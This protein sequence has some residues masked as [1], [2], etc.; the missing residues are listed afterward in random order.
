VEDLAVINDEYMPMRINPSGE[1]I[2]TPAGVYKVS[3]ESVV[4]YYPFDEQTCH[5]K[6][7]TSGYTQGEIDLRFDEN[8]VD[9]SDYIPNGEWEVASAGGLSSGEQSK[10]RNGLKYASLSFELKLKRR[11]L[12]HTINTIFPVFLMGMLIPFV[13]KLSIMEEKIGYSLTVLLSYAVYL[14]LIADHIPS[15]SVT[16]CYLSVYLAVILTTSTLS[17]LIV[18]VEIQVATTKGSLSSCTKAFANFL[19]N[20]CCFKRKWCRNK[21]D[22]APEVRADE[23]YIN[24]HGILSSKE[25]VSENTEN[26]SDI[27]DNL[28]RT[29]FMDTKALDDYMFM[30][31]NFWATS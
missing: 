16:V 26:A 27:N 5:I 12:F 19:A 22:R 21:T 9:L 30:D 20:V 11:Y 4:T 23:F 31:T 3:C 29:Q 28:V 15:T 13:F 7:T 1:V 24:R 6:I 2:R 8:A 25:F 10:S 18:I 14:T 17:I